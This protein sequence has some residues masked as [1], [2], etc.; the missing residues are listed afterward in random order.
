MSLQCFQRTSPVSFDILYTKLLNYL[1][2]TDSHYL[3][4]QLKKKQCKDRNS[5]VVSLRNLIIDN[6]NMDPPLRDLGDIFG[7]KHGTIQYILDNEYANQN[8]I[9]RPH[10]FNDDIES[11]FIEII[12]K[13]WNK[14]KPLTKNQFHSYIL[15]ETGKNVSIG[16]IN[17]FLDR[18]EDKIKLISGIPLDSNK[19]NVKLSEII[20]FIDNLELASIDVIPDLFFN[21]DETGINPWTDAKSQDVFC[22]SSYE[23]SYCNIPIKRNFKNT[24]V[25]PCCSLS[26]DTITP[27]II[28]SR[29]SIDMSVYQEGIREGEDIMIQV[30]KKG[31]VT[32]QYFILWLINIFLPY[33]NNIR[34]LRVDNYFPAL[35]L[36]D[37]HAAHKSFEVKQILAQNNIRL[38][39]FPPNTTHFLQPLDLVSFHAFK[40]KIY[41]EKLKNEYKCQHCLLT[42]IL[43]CI[44]ES[45]TSV[46]CRSS[47]RRAGICI[48]TNSTLSAIEINREIIINNYECAMNNV[49]IIEETHKDETIK[50]KSKSFG[51]I[52]FDDFIHM[53]GDKCPCC[54]NLYVN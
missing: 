12:M 15:H 48:N 50:K 19:L 30:S 32:K 44:E 34:H 7:V 24:T 20:E 8:N 16:Y 31:Y 11:L 45:T 43:D 25:M 37:N 1:S 36:T 9:G 42:K 51:Y 10:S 49:P 47:F 4:I 14:H 23:G 6:Y 54:G 3:I 5:Q 21:L 22:P 46:K 41:K 18:H 40:S 17:Y 26:G 2:E 33:V 27:L 35:L 53:D 39:T 28:I 38:V 13:G 29:L 52:N